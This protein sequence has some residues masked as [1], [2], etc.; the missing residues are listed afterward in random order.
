MES[1]PYLDILDIMD[2]VACYGD[3][4][5]TANL[6]IYCILDRIAI[7]FKKFVVK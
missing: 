4:S 1:A 7:Y 6:L 5:P 3:K 2:D